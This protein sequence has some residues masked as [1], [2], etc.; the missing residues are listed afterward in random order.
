[1][2]KSIL[3]RRALAIII[4][5]I[6]TFGTIFNITFS[7]QLVTLIL[8]I[9]ATFVSQNV[10]F[11]LTFKNLDERS[12]TIKKNIHQNT[13]G[14]LI[15]LIVFCIGSITILETL[16]AVSISGAIVENDWRSKYIFLYVILPVLTFPICVGLWEDKEKLIL[17]P[18]L[19]AFQIFKN[20]CKLVISAILIVILFLFSFLSAQFHSD[21]LAFLFS[22]SKIVLNNNMNYK[23]TIDKN[24]QGGFINTRGI[25][26]KVEDVK[27]ST[28]DKNGKNINVWSV[29]NQ[30]ALESNPD[31]ILNIG[32][33]TGNGANALT[34]RLIDVTAEITLS[35]LTYLEITKAKN[36]EIELINQ[37]CL[38]QDSLEIKVGQVDN[39]ILPC[40]SK[41]KN[42][43][44]NYKK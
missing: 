17:N 11:M 38:E 7:V 29:E 13:F 31:D 43:K 20:I 34:Y 16:D 24:L 35:S 25:K 10:Q 15:L 40:L 32:Y 30:Q 2:T 1:M 3:I 33:V 4:F 26:A 14:K 22:Q 28:V 42:L 37:E 36:V 9:V 44:T 39:L 6:A 12:L 41:V 19:N 21:E 8:C 23:I 27:V 18:F 5:V